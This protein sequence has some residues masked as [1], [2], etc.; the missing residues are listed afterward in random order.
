MRRLSSFVYGRAKQHGRPSVLCWKD[1]IICIGTNLAKILMFGSNQEIKAVYAPSVSLDTIYGTVSALALSPDGTKLAAGFTS[2]YIIVWSVKDAE[3]PLFSISPLTELPRTNDHARNQSHL[4]GSVIRFVDFLDRQE[5]TLVSADNK[6]MVFVHCPFWFLAGRTR[7]ICLLGNYSPRVK[8]TIL[9]FKKF[10]LNGP[11]HYIVSV[12]TP[13]TFLLSEFDVANLALRT[14]LRIPWNALSDSSP[15]TSNGSIAWNPQSS[16]LA[17]SWNNEI[18]IMQIQILDGQVVITAHRAYQHSKNIN[19][20]LWMDKLLFIMDTYQQATFLDIENLEVVGHANMEDK[21]ALHSGNASESLEYTGSS[22]LDAISNLTVA[23]QDKSVLVLG[24]YEVIM[25]VCTS[26]ADRLLYLLDNSRP[27]DAVVLATQYYCQDSDLDIIGLDVNKRRD[28]LASAL[29]DLVSAALKYILE[30][31]VDELHHL[32]VACLTC[33]SATKQPLLDLINEILEPFGLE[34]ELL[35]VLSSFVLN[36]SIDT[37]SPTVFKGLISYKPD[38]PE[39]QDIIL[40]LDP[41]NIDLDL[42]FLLCR[43]YDFEQAEI[44][45]TTQA[46]HD[47]VAP[48]VQNGEYV[49]V[50]LSYILSGKVY[51]TGEPLEDSLLAQDAIYTF[52]FESPN[53]N[54]KYLIQ[55][56]SAQFFSAMNTAFENTALNSDSDP[57]IRLS[58][59]RQILAQ[60]L[61]KI[62]TG[63]MVLSHPQSMIHFNIFLARNYAKYPQYLHIP[64]T[65]LDRL[66]FELSE[67]ELLPDECQ[68]ALMS[69]LSMYKPPNMGEVL[70]SLKERHR[71]AVLEQLYRFKNDYRNLVLLSIDAKLPSLWSNIREG[72]RSARNQV[73]PLIVKHLQELCEIDSLEMG[74]LILGCSMDVFDS[75]LGLL[76]EIR[77]PLLDQIFEQIRLGNYHKLPPRNVCDEYVRELALRNG[78]RLFTMLNTV[79]V[80]ADDIHLPHVVDALL[81]HSRTDALVVLLSR[82]GRKSEAMIYL[83]DH[84]FKIANNLE[85]VQSYSVLGVNICTEV[86]RA[87]KTEGVT[88][89][90][91]LLRTILAVNQD[92][93]PILTALVESNSEGCFVKVVDALISDLPDLPESFRFLEILAKIIERNDVFLKALK[94]LL[95]MESFEVLKQVTRSRIHGWAITVDGICEACGENIIGIGVDAEA[96]YDFWEVQYR[97]MSEN[98]VNLDEIPLSSVTNMTLVLFGCRHNYH[99]KCLLRLNKRIECIICEEASGQPHLRA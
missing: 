91:K 97:Q 70:T 89:W 47:F 99:L 36:R 16:M 11:D 4:K 12:L 53:S 83:I 38:R 98:C 66:I 19:L 48:I 26:W 49:Y 6:G 21:H 35:E 3:H 92:A 46:L 28:A 71:F 31:D 50:Y 96:L 55:K 43:K 54:V 72:L 7:S 9:A 10:T 57:Q 52:L 30:Y 69:V 82:Q 37:L 93:T 56:D 8:T 34:T 45:L 25:G 17:F 76:N 32:L 88:L 87:N 77:F 86:S 33:V 61:G 67:S 75:I 73:Y 58:I 64:G 22:L 20:I 24:K 60:R 81:E 5:A 68:L 14:V 42:A 62:M 84:I 18:R 79:F 78:Q 13:Y 2:G 27:I 40:S 90:V 44:F 15:T 95:G 41:S 63:N 74:K 51:P 29:P 94:H 80:H 85:D 39:T 65:R 59:D 1:N 23:V